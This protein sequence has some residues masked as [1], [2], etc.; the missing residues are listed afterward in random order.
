MI[1]DDKM[2]WAIDTCAKISK[3]TRKRERS[4]QTHQK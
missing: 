4:V 2:V 3:H 1:K